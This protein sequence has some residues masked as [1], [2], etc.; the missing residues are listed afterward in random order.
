MNKQK[1]LIATST[2]VFATVIGANISNR[3]GAQTED[4][5]PLAIQKLIEKFNLNTDEVDKVLEEV[6]TQKQ[7]EH[8]AQLEEKLNTAVQEGKITEDQKSAILN[9]LE[10]WQNAKVDWQNL[11]LEERKQKMLEHKN[12]MQ[13]WAESNGI[14]L[15]DILG[16]GMHKKGFIHEFRAGW[17]Q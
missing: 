7:V 14:N 5:Y 2:L 10:E 12:E 13:N 17:S 15:K 1:I 11:S 4:K 16:F 9:K 6:K 3:V 8:R